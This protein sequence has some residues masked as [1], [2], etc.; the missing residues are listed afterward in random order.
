MAASAEKTLPANLAE[1]ATEPEPKTQLPEE[2][3]PEI[4]FRRRQNL[5]QQL[6]EIWQFREFGLTLAERDLRA[7][8]KQATLGFAWALIT[9][10]LLMLAFTLIFTKFAK[11]D[12]HGVPYPVYSYVALIPW[13]FFSASV[14][15]GANSMLANLP[16]LQRVYCPRELF[17]VST[18]LGAA[19]DAVLSVFVLGILFAVTGTTPTTQSLYLLILIPLLIAFTLAVTLACAGLLV[20]FRDLRH[21]LPLLLQ[22]VLLATPVGYGFESISSSRAFTLFYSAVNPLAPIIDGFRRVVLF[23]SAPDWGALG[24]AGVVSLLALVGA[25]RLFKRLETG[26]A[27]IA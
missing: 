21:A 26:F 17:P 18:M 10:L 8:Y 7:R 12:S 6:R 19:V 16:L 25:Y 23:G 11:V 2:P 20:Y 1:Q 27:D 24:I 9:P 13:T 4:W 22:F 5:G 15:N 14:S 3:R